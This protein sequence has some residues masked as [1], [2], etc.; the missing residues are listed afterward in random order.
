MSV[1][2]RVYL[3]L[4]SAKAAA[5]TTMMITVAAM[6]MYSVIDDAGLLGGAAGVGVTEGGTDGADVGAGADVTEGEAG[7]CAAGAAPTPKAVSAYEP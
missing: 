5:A 6:A 4:L 7:T 2:F 3:R 1:F